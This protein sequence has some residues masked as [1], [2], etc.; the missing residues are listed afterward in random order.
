MDIQAGL[1]HQG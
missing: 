1:E